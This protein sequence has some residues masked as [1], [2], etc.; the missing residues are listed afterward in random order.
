MQ[1]YRAALPGSPAAEY[2]KR[3]GIRPDSW[4]SSLLGWV[5][6]GI[7]RKEHAAN[8]IAIAYMT[9]A[10]IV[11][12][13]LRAI[14]DETRPKYCYPPG[15]QHRLFNV[16]ALSNN[17]GIVALTE[18]EL[19]AIIVQQQTGIPCLSYP[20]TSAW[21]N[22]FA[23]AFAGLEQVLVI[24]D[25]DVPGREAAK[26]VSGELGRFV[27]RVRVVRMPDDHDSNSFFLEYGADALTEMLKDG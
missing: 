19:D 1:D 13:K 11:D 24:A 14:D 18:G 15:T 12:M 9:P 21:K 6:E 5:G 17:D 20:G 10:G 2:A 4:T 27:D 26:T 25:G 22:Y 16:P 3:R 23:R 7:A 8:R